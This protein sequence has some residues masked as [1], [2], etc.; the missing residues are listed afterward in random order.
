MTD[1]I[2]RGAILSTFARSFLIQGSWNYRTMLGTGFGFA[3]LPALRKL[4][5]D[6]PDELRAALARHTEHFNA[7]PYLS[8]VALGATLRLEADGTDSETVRRFKTAVRGPLGGLGDALVWATFLPS[9]SMLALAAYWLGAPGPAAAVGFLVVYNI[10]HVTLRA[11]G[12]R[13]GLE[14]GRDVGGRLAAARLVH[15]AARLRDA[16]V[17]VLG[18]LAGA[19]LGGAGGLGDAGIL[20]GAGAVGAFV[21]GLLV[22]HYVWRP[23]AATTVAVIVLVAIWGMIR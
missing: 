13:A 9:V 6:R 1:R 10:G 16:S 22:G 11:W 3:L 7:H 17:V 8:G 21:L 2:S 15:H 20:W 4:F 19:L 18:T 12:F 14:T 23:A 5:R